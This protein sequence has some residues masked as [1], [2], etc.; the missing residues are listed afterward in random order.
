[1]TTVLTIESV[2]AHVFRVPIR[3]PV[4]VSFGTLTDRPAVLVEVRDTD[5]CVGWGESFCN[6]PTVGAEHRGRLINEVIAPQLVGTSVENPAV[7]FDQITARY[8]VLALQCG[9]PGSFAQSI[10]GIDVALWDLCARRA[11]TPLYRYLGGTHDAVPVYASGLGPGD[12]AGLGRAKRAAGYDA[13]KLKVGFGADADLANLSALR[14]AVGPDATV[15]VD[16]NQAWDV[17]TAIEMSRRLAPL[18]PQ[19][20]EEP[21]RADAPLEDWRRLAKEGSLPLAAGENIRGDAD[22]DTAIASGCFRVLQPDII[23]W[24]GISRIREIA[25]RIRDAGL[26]YCPHYLGGGVGLVASAHLL[27]AIGGDGRLE[28]DAN[29]NPLRDI[30]APLPPLSSG[31]LTLSEGPGLGVDPDFGRLAPYRTL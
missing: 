16:A 21:L 15:F 29:P 24:G 31:R 25:A 30:I 5:G 13:F 19:W 7:V 3:A 20:L 4:R 17:G 14:E 26:T 27:A 18:G 8:E 22:F 6:W 12:V 10:A 11:E 28:V 1:M 2:R 23:K 9:E